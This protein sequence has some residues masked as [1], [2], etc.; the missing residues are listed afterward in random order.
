MIIDKIT[1]NNLAKKYNINL[2]VVNFDEWV[3]GLNIE[4]EHGSRNSQLTN[5]TNDDADMTAKIAIAHLLQDPRYYYFLKIQ[6]SER[7]KY[8]INKSKPNIFNVSNDYNSLTQDNPPLSSYN[9][10]N[11]QPSYNSLNPQPSYNSLNPQPSY[12]S[13]NRRPNRYDNINQQP[14]RYNNSNRL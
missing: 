3:T 13:L 9:S 14:S 10:L 2:N 1:A 11:P 7:T 4:L 6:E 8:W 12:N 5:I